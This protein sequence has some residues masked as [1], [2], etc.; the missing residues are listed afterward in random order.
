[1]DANGVISALLQSSPQDHFKV[2][3]VAQDVPPVVAQ[4]PMDANGVLSKVYD[5]ATNSIRVVGV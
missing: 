2:N 4:T 1:M 5:S 3:V